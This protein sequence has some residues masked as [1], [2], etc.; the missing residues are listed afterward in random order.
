[1]NTCIDYYR[2][3]KVEEDILAIKNKLSKK[4]IKENDSKLKLKKNSIEFKV[5]SIE[6]V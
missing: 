5:V 2:L 6:S 3:L 4:F 1:M